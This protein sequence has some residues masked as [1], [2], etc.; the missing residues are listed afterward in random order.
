VSAQALLFQVDEI[1]I[2]ALSLYFAV[3]RSE[4]APAVA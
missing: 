1:A 4:C 2:A 3:R